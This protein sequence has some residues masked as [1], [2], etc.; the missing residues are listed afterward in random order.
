M[1]RGSQ[2][3]HIFSH[4][5][6]LIFPL[7]CPQSARLTLGMTGQSVLGRLERE[8]F[9]IWWGKM[10]EMNGENCWFS[11]LKVGRV[12]FW[13]LV[14]YE[15]SW[16]KM[17][18]HGGQRRQE[19]PK[20]GIFHCLLWFLAGFH[21]RKT[22]LF[23]LLYSGYFD[24][25]S[26][27]FHSRTNALPKKYH[28]STISFILIVLKDYEVEQMAKDGSFTL[29]WFETAISVR[30]HSYHLPFLHW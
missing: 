17:A 12:Q 15:Q 19:W 8:N 1:Q 3:Y 25:A 30:S 6:I 7:L 20:M 18:K 21:W 11:T 29:L 28:L 27:L 2:F 5:E 4:P 14:F 24:F 16:P 23:F 10:G 9:Q 13:F 26:S 22:A